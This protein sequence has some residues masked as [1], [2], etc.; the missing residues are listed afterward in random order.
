MDFQ[1]RYLCIYL[2]VNHE[3]WNSEQANP[4][5]TY[6][7]DQSQDCSYVEQYGNA[8]FISNLSLHLLEN[9]VREFLKQAGDI[10]SLRIK[11]TAEGAKVACSYTTEQSA[12]EALRTFD[13]M[14]LQGRRLH[15]Q[16]SPDTM[17]IFF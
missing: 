16:T 10:W 7:T 12:A 4:E 17:H 5:W 9:D 14:E 8:V 1:G 2:Q 3:S 6:L 13:G 11:I 15:A